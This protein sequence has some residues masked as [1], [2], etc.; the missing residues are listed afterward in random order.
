MKHFKQSRGYWCCSQGTAQVTL[1]GQPMATAGLSF[2]QQQGHLAP[3]LISPGKRTLPAQNQIRHNQPCP[4]RAACPAA[5]TSL[6]FSSCSSDGRGGK[7]VHS[8]PLPSDKSFRAHAKI[9]KIKKFFKTW[10]T[11]FLELMSAPATLLG[12]QQ[13]K[14][15]I[16]P[17]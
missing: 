11:C 3:F 4:E 16:L 17:T 8:D 1:P 6:W 10:L 5:C 14:M 7:Q 15:N 13:K 9:L 12:L 2:H